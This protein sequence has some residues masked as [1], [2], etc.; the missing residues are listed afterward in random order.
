MMDEYKPDLMLGH[1]GYPQLHLPPAPEASQTMGAGNSFHEFAAASSAQ[2][3]MRYADDP[4]G[5]MLQGVVRGSPGASEEATSTWMPG[6]GTASPGRGGDDRSHLMQPMQPMPLG[7]G[8]GPK[9]QIGAQKKEQRIRRPMNAFMVWAKV[10]RKKLADENPDLHNAD[11]SKMLGKKWKSLTPQ[12]RRPFVEEAEH[13]RVIHMQEHPDYKYRPRRRK[14]NKRGG[15]ANPGGANPGG[16][17]TQSGRR[18]ES[19][20]SPGGSLLQQH[21][22]Q[23]PR[24]A[25]SPAA[26]TSPFRHLSNYASS[27]S[28]ASY[29]N[30]S[31]MLHTPDS[32]PTGSPEPGADSLRG[33]AKRTS[34]EAVASREHAAHARNVADGA[35]QHVPVPAAA[36]EQEKF[37]SFRQQQQQHHHQQQQQ[38]QRFFNGGVAPA[39]H[40]Q[41]PTGGAIVMGRSGAIPSQSYPGRTHYES[42]TSTFYP[43]VVIPPSSAAAS[44]ATA[45]PPPAA[46]VH[47][48]Y[49][50]ANAAASS[51]LA[52]GM[53][54]SPSGYQ[55]SLPGARDAC[56]GPSSMSDDLSAATGT[57]RSTFQS[58]HHHHQ[59]QVSASDELLMDAGQL[60]THEFDRYLNKSQHDMDSNH[61][62]QHQIQQQQHHHHQAVQMGYYQQQQQQHQAAVD[63]LKNEAEY[64]NGD[65]QMEQQ[66]KT[67][68][69]FSLIL[70]DVRKTC[71]N[72]S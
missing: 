28:P 11:L 43:P 58:A 55:Q 61:N 10:E 35:G 41:L 9:G 1:S 62:Y 70:A 48:M 25:A 46:S 45:S 18:S 68:D 60:D 65:L 12:D 42:V 69:D 22:Y 30:P 14:H 71:Y 56:Q 66:I 33:M 4:S 64:G 8:G 17:A 19:S 57:C 31:P 59:F 67:E 49:N 44:A 6:F 5:H 29:Y 27:S 24:V 21:L 52:Y 13:L 53:H 50:G 15:G 3:Y 37:K 7:G 63:A 47:S 26:P 54:C 2:Y 20:R 40:F 32:S 72:S 39:H 16:A 38:Q 23:Q 51:Y 36:A 34:P